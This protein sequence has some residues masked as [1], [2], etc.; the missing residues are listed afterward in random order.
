MRYLRP[1]IGGSV[2]C[3]FPLNTWG[4]FMSCGTDAGEDAGDRPLPDYGRVFTLNRKAFLPL[5]QV[6]SVHVEFQPVHY[7]QWQEY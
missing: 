5:Q 3:A 6:D 4:A 1:R 7:C 2:I